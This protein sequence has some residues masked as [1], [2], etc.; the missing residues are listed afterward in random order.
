MP[1]IILT[2]KQLVFLKSYPKK[3]FEKGE[4]I[5]NQGDEIRHV[6]FLVAGDC[7][8]KEYTDSGE[9]VVYDRRVANNCSNDFIAV[10]YSYILDKTSSF[11]YSTDNGCELNII[12]QKD[13]MTFLS[14][15][16][17]LMH[18][19]LFRIYNRYNDLNQNYLS[20]R[21]NKTIE[22]ICAI[23]KKYAREDNG[24]FIVD[25]KI[26]VT[27]IAK[28]VGSHRVTVSKI[29][30]KLTQENIIEKS[31]A[32]IRIKDMDKLDDYAIEIDNVD[33]TL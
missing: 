8:R 4:T 33:F 27:E 12:P 6:Y 5:I 20:K 30:T 26:S 19:L 31:P 23:L 32:G 14:E 21:S 7:S 16:P 11:T 18:G 2:D 25:K 22:L 24:I 29:I 10:K 9:E 3:V 17:E 13:F 15:N 1:D 28:R